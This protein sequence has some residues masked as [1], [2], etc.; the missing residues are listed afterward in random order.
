[1]GIHNLVVCT[2][3]KF[4]FTCTNI[5]EDLIIP[6]DLQV[7]NL[8]NNSSTLVPTRKINVDNWQRTKRK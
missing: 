1:M 3:E 4:L 7:L 5:N 8:N 2:L 6:K